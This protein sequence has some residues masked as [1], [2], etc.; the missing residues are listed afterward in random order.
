MNYWG[1]VIAK[2]SSKYKENLSGVL[3][4]I[5]EKTIV[6]HSFKYASVTARKY[7]SVVSSLAGEFLQPTETIYT[8]TIDL[9]FSKGAAVKMHE[10]STMT[11]KD[12]EPVINVDTGQT[13]AIILYLSGGVPNEYA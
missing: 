5:G 12:I 6:N 9:P 3:V 11:I 4:L 1:K 2:D 8:T 10:G 7:T 13:K